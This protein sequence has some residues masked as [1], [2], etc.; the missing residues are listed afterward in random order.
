MPNR[1]GT[2]GSRSMFWGTAAPSL[3]F[4]SRI[5]R[6]GT[7]CQRGAWGECV[8]AAFPQPLQNSYAAGKCTCCYCDISHSLAL[9]NSLSPNPIALFSPGFFLAS[10]NAHASAC[11]GY[12]CRTVCSVGWRYTLP[13]LVHH[14]PSRTTVMMCTTASQTHCKQRYLHF[15]AHPHFFAMFF[16]ISK[17][18]R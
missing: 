18:N 8:W 15:R 3:S 14:L 16:V 4:T 12:I 1:K 13:C 11:A 17:N 7:A 5:P 10:T 9:L 2:A 6:H